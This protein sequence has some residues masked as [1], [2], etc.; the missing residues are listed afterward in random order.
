MVR[1]IDRRR[2]KGGTKRRLE[3]R[4][5]TRVVYGQFIDHYPNVFGTLPEKIVYRELLLRKIPFK[6]QTWMRVQVPEIGIDK[7]YLPDFWLPNDKIIIEV[8]GYY[9]HS[10]PEAIEKDALKAA[11]WQSKGFKVI[12]WWDFDIEERIHELI[13]AV[14]ELAS[15]AGRA[16]G[17]RIITSDQVN[18][19]DSKGIVTLNQRKRQPYKKVIKHKGKRRKSTARSIYT[20]GSS[21]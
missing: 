2:K 7:Y 13:A 14:P 4:N 17:G 8:Q 10:T 21:F 20:G 15:R 19:D 9:W 6:Y 3:K 12:H 11:L 1:I 18:R 5:R 16:K